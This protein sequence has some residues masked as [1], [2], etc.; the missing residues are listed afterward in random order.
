VFDWLFLPFKIM[1]NLLIKLVHHLLHHLL[2][3]LRLPLLIPNLLLLILNIFKLKPC[4][5]HLSHSSIILIV[6]FLHLRPCFK[7]RLQSIR[8][9]IHWIFVIQRFILLWHQVLGWFQL[10]LFHLILIR[11]LIIHFIMI[12]VH[13]KISRLK[14]HIFNYYFHFLH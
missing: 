9:F 11:L 6:I 10:I 7:F 2:I 12:I 5:L 8:S 14:D 4:T 13:L 1:L 3:T